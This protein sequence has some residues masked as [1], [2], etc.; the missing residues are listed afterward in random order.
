L[1]VLFGLLQAKRGFLF[2]KNNF[3][4]D[5]GTLFVQGCG[6]G[7]G[8][9]WT[10]I[11]LESCIHV[12]AKSWILIRKLDKIQELQRLKMEAWRLRGSKWSP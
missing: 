3:E 4:K 11:S 8:F 5:S 9:A 2:S 6:S 1:D 10:R 12:R 7:F